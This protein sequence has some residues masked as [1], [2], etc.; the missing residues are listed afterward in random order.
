[1]KFKRPVFAD[2]ATSGWFPVGGTAPA[3]ASA[4]EHARYLALPVIALAL[5]MAA[6]L[7]SERIFEGFLGSPERTFFYGH[8][9]CG[10]PLGAAVA[11]EVVRCC[12]STF[13][14]NNNAA[15]KL[16]AKISPRPRT[17]RFMKP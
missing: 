8:T 6:T 3:G 14:A 11:R 5:P 2:T 1:M 12:A 4:L 17:R 10:N 16:N 15:N 13:D 9:F 7:A